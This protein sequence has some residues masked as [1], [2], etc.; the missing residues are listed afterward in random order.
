MPEVQEIV[1]IPMDVMPEVPEIVEIPMDFT[2]E[3]PEIPEA[4]KDISILSEL[5]MDSRSDVVE[6]SVLRKHRR[7]A[8]SPVTNYLGA[9]YFSQKYTIETP[10]KRLCLYE[11]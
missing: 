6:D 7:P 10:Q 3:V 2:P 4:T 8:I 11:F 5:S 9:G 1:E